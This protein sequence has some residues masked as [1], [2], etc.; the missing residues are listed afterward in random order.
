MAE[1]F[2]QPPY[3]HCITWKWKKIKKATAPSQ[4]THWK[5]EALLEKQETT[6]ERQLTFV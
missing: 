2:H 3:V 1:D 6:K 5:G 4:L